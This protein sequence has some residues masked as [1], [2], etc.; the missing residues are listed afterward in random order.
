MICIDVILLHIVGCDPTPCNFANITSRERQ[1]CV[2]S[3]PCYGTLRIDDVKIL[4][5][6][7]LVLSG[8][9]QCIGLDQKIRYFGQL[10]REGSYIA[11]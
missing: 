6:T 1:I 2:R 10:I 8:S 4:G 11:I 7:I 9:L 3:F 5:A